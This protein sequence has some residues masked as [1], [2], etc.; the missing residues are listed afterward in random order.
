MPNGMALD[1]QCHMTQD[2][3]M[4]A[5]PA[6][7]AEF[8]EHARLANDPVRALGAFRT[9]EAFRRWSDEKPGRM[10][11]ATTVKLPGDLVGMVEVGLYDHGMLAAECI[12]S[13]YFDALAHALAIAGAA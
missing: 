8:I 5:T 10:M 1:T 3:C 9:I 7:P 4:N 13:D 12:S 11:R 6:S 2:V